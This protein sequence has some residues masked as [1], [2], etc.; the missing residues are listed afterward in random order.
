MGHSQMKDRTMIKVVI[1]SHMEKKF[2]P[3]SEWPA[4]LQIAKDVG[5]E[6][7]TVYAWLDERIARV[8]LKL[9]DKWCKYFDVQTGD[10]LVRE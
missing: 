8:D 5:I 2:G 7:N 10:I 9:L 3:E 4:K 1:R 6:P